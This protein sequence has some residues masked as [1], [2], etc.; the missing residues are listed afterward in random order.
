MDF[1]LNNIA[2]LAPGYVIIIGAIGV[3]YV[4][5]VNKLFSNK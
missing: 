5:H 3:L 2:T 4:C 1:I